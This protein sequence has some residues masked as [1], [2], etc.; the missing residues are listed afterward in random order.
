LRGMLGQLDWRGVYTGES[1]NGEAKGG[2]W[3]LLVGKG[4]SK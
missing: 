3:S 4:K 1:A 2:G